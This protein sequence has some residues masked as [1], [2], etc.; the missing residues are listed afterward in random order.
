MNDAKKGILSSKQI[1][2]VKDIEENIVGYQNYWKQGSIVSTI[3]AVIMAIVSLP[4]LKT[5]MIMLLPVSAIFFVTAIGCFIKYM[6]IKKGA[7]FYI[8]EDVCY[9]TRTE[10]DDEGFV[11]GYYITFNKSGQHKLTDIIQ[12]AEE[13]YNKAFAGDHFYLVFAKGKKA[14]L[15]V[16]P[17]KEYEIDKTQFVLKEGK[18][19]PV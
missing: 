4:F 10:T 3:I 13:I 2:N 9:N 14:P 19:H 6:T 8:L 7:K 11:Y 5:P 17:C 16:I 12:S 1:L 15:F 18:Y